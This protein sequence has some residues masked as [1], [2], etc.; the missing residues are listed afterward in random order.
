MNFEI[1]NEM[2]YTSKLVYSGSFIIYDRGR[3]VYQSNHRVINQLTIYFIT[4][5]RENFS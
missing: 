1:K 5:V 3:I 2:T 4:L